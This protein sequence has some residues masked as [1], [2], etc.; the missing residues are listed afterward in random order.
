MLHA[1]LSRVRVLD[2]LA[3]AVERECKRRSVGQSTADEYLADLRKAFDEAGPLVASWFDPDC[4]V[5][6]ERSIYR[7]D[8]DEAFR[9]DRVVIS[10]DGAVTVV[11]Y[12][13]TSEPR[14][15]H[16]AQVENYISLMRSLGRC[17]VVGYLW[18]PLLGRVIKVGE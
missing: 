9:P 11:D 16:F 15:T 12:K 5:F 3:G 6:S 7:S 18:Y 17:S 13:F 8:D 14:P 1:V 10:P 2:D 4:R